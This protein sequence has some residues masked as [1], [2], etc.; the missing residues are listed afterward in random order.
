MNT[1]TVSNIV[2]DTDSD[3]DQV[4]DDGTP[5]GALEFAAQGVRAFNHRS[6]QPFERGSE[7][8]EY[9]SDA[10]RCL[11]ELTRLAYGLAQAFDQIT[12]ALRRELE[13]DQLGIDAGTTWA[14]DPAGAV[15][16][17]AAALT[18]AGEAA[19]S[20]GDASLQAQVALVGAHYTGPT[21]DEA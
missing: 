3:T 18:A 7:G 6:R 8:W 14:D 12:A 2:T 5:V 9:P 20:M 13:L 11:G 10:Y 4:G 15:R 16:T 21:R 17:A 19:R 1:D